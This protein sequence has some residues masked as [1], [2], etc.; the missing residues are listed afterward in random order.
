[1]ASESPGLI[2][3]T[4][5]HYKVLERLGKGGTGDA[6]KA[7]DLDLERLVA[8]KIL[9][10]EA[11]FGEEAR[12]RL[13]AQAAAAAALGDP[14]LCAI[15]ETGET[16]DGQ[17]YVVTPFCEGETLADRLRQA[18]LPPGRAIELA[19]RIAAAV[20]RA[21]AHGIVHGDLKPG[22]VLITPEGEVRL[23]DFGLAGLAHPAAGDAL[24]YR[25]PE[26][27]RGE[28]EADP[29]S[30]VW[31][32]GVLLYQML[33]GRLPYA[34]ADA[35]GLLASIGGGTP[36]PL[37]A[38]APPALAPILAAALAREPAR[39]YSGAAELRDDLAAAEGT[40]LL[41]ASLGTTLLEMPLAGL[42]VTEREGS[43]G[44]A[45]AAAVRPAGEGPAGSAEEEASPGAGARS[46]MIGRTVAHYRILDHLGTGGMGVVYKAAD[47][48]LERTVA[49]KF[50]PYALTRDQRAKERFLQE[51]RAASGLDHPNICT[52]HE[53]GET[54]EGQL[55]LA[56]ACYDG[57]T[58]GRRIERGPLPVAEAIDIARQ[59]AQGLAK[60]HRAGIVHRD[61]KPANLMLTADGLVKILDFGIAKLAKAAG[62]TRVGFAVGT[63]AYMSPEQARG[64]D[65]DP[66]TDVWALGVVL[67]EMLTAERPFRGADREAV[68]A[69]LQ[70]DE[71][72]RLST[73][74]PE[75]P[76]ELERIVGRM[77]AKSPEDRY[78]N[79]AEALA[80]L[81]AL[82]AARPDAARRWSPLRAGLGAAL[83]LALLG[84]GGYLALRGGKRGPV[85][86]SFARLTD[87]GGES[88]PSL[89]PDGHWFAYVKTSLDGKGE[90]YRQQ[91][92]SAVPQRL[93]L[94][95]P[96]SSSQ[97]AISP[98]GRR[99]AFRS[100]HAGGGVFVMNADGS[101][102]AKLSAFGFNPAWSPHGDALVVATEP[103]TD[104]AVRVTKSQLWRIDVRTRRAR[105]LT[106][107]DAV[108]PSWSPNGQRIAYWGLPHSTARRVLWTMPAAGGAAQE[109]LDDKN[110]NWDPVWSPDGKYLYL[111]SDRGGSMGFWRIAIDASG[112]P[113]GDL[114]SVQT[115]AQWAG[116][117][118]IA[119]DGQHLAF[120]SVTR[121][122]NLFRT[123]LDAAA[124]RVDGALQGITQGE[125]AVRSADVS[126]DGQRVVFDYA[127][128]Q[129]DLFLAR[130]DG[131]EVVALTNDAFKDRI[132]RWSPDGKRILFYSNR[133]GSYEAWTIGPDGRGLRRETFASNRA[134][135]F[136]LWS[137]D[138][139]RIALSPESS[140]LAL[141][142]LAP[143][144]SWRRIQVLDRAPGQQ[145]FAATSWSPDSQRLA[146]TVSLPNGTGLDGIALYSLASHRY[147]RISERG[148]GAVW[149]HRTP[150]LLYLD[151]GAIHLLDV[152]TRRTLLLLRPAAGSKFTW[153]AVDGNDSMLYLVQTRET[154]VVGM[155]T[156]E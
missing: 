146:G 83:A 28:A 72:P 8:I 9:P 81:A 25:S 151:G 29:P 133:S 73:V 89:A 77:L 109:V 34:G 153:V 45:G 23:V 2:G 104:P 110:L 10:A 154:G 88:S 33:T 58:L 42:E 53:V 108:Q 103:V 82:E 66:R 16:G 128:P 19:G 63:P 36:A 125:R 21:H 95:I 39:R 57:E 24:A 18:P 130:A 121:Q 148:T 84:I 142:D 93:T 55:Y 3:S 35:A 26:Q 131:T 119:Q 79:V 113:H 22:N 97:P 132:P 149:L 13:L 145:D 48:K 76:P 4:L 91:V 94:G 7:L 111:A 129:E 155:L 17:P 47:T 15:L 65:V 31:A 92:T 56:M 80:D 106:A 62:A 140:N 135:Y 49:L 51:A 99:I 152:P 59:T 115:P 37:P 78:P 27:L 126:P 43:G 117:L 44:R 118:S 61:V 101:G 30:D 124:G 127:T 96:E 38:A 100:E 41:P 107:G 60:A 102:I 87:L 141:V 150:K 137:P 134:L 123:D 139:R 112:K 138:Q 54:A 69:A 71:P 75:V 136:P 90:I 5:S 64:E 6:W 86:T 68:V 147:E 14:Q 52:I 1:V 85:Q 70:R 67:Y 143:P 105:L 74:R 50:L 46:G 12:R 144:P 122:A 156:L 116:F 20:A 98:D 120:A 11:G 114:Q 32:L 40:H